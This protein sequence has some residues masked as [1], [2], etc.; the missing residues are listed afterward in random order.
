ME[1]TVITEFKACPDGEI[2]P[3]KAGGKDSHHK[4]DPMFAL[5][6]AWSQAM[7]VPDGPRRRNAPK[8][9]TPGGFVSAVPGETHA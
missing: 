9:W 6:T 8:V 5:L 2:Y 1:A 7:L 3:R 4:I